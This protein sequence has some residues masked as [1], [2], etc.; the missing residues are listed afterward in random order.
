[1]KL[2]KCEFA[3]QELE[4]LGHIISSMGVATDPKKTQAMRDWYV[5]ASTIEL[6]GFLDLTGYYRKFVKDYGS[7]VEPLTNLLKKKQF[8]WSTKA[9]AAFDRLK[10][11]ISSTPVLALPDFSNPFLVETDASDIEFGAVLMQDN[12]P[13]A[14]ISKPLSVTHKSLSIYEKE[15][16]AL[17]LAVDKWRQYL[18]RHEFIIRTDHKNLAY[19]NDQVV[20]SKLQKKSND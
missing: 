15:L 16:L 11:A 19:L 13:V 17:I 3:Q 7:I 4:Y 8:M 10:S 5:P 1:V 18:Q 2:S 20:Q 6:R 12:K 14:F 9:Q